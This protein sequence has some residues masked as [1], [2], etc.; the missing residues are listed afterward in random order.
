MNIFEIINAILIKKGGKPM[1]LCLHKWKPIL[2][3]FRDTF[4]GVEIEKEY[5]EYRK[6]MRCGKMQ[7]MTGCGMDYYWEDL[8]PVEQNILEDLLVD[9]G[10]YFTLKKGETQ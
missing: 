5:V 6:C 3:S 8:I 1:K 9:E 2:K 7:R 4:E 10:K